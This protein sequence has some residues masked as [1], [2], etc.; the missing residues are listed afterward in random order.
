[1]K[2]AI[3]ITGVPGAGKT[4]IGSKLKDRLSEY[5]GE[6][7]LLND[8]KYF[9]EWFIKNKDRQDLVEILGEGGNFNLKP[10]AYTEMSPWVTS[11]LAED[12]ITS[13]EGDQ[14]MVLIEG[15]RGVGEP[16]A[17]YAEHLVVPVYEGI[18]RVHGDIR[19]ANLE[20]SAESDKIR[21][22]LEERYAKDPESA[23]PSVVEKYLQEN[24]E[25][26]SSSVAE[27]EKLREEKFGFPLL[28]NEGLPNGSGVN[29]IE[30]LAELAETKV[31]GVMSAWDKEGGSYLRRG[32]ER[33]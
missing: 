9:W 24:G 3:F 7:A 16:M 8:Y 12:A 11:R 20:V 10:K 2:I 33:G 19:V 29:N 5:K 1:M 28:I 32:K 22:R 23:P 21:E 6:V 27:L 4:E 17:G 25:P 15:A 26:R 13:L 14:D 31:I 18:R 30:R